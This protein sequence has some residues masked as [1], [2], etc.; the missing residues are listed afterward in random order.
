M[1]TPTRLED[2]SDADLVRQATAGHREAFAEI[3]RRYHV[4]VYR[5]ARM[6]S[7]SRAISASSKHT[8]GRGAFISKW[9]VENDT[10]QLL[11][12]EDLIKKIYRFDGTAWTQIPAG[13]APLNIGWSVV[14]VPP[15]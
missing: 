12:G 3:Y 9:V 7:G 10:L 15:T 13:N 6:T 2:T 11:R 4:I 5:V 8:G 14:C 1:V